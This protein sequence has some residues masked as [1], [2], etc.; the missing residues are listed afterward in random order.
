MRRGAG[1][2]GRMGEPR[3]QLVTAGRR[4]I[5]ERP[6]LTKLLDETSARVIMLVAPA[7]Y[8]KTTL[9][10][11]WLNDRPHIWHQAGQASGDFAS[12]GMGISGA[13]QAV[14]GKNAR[15]FQEWLT[16]RSGA[17][18]PKIGIGLLAADLAEWPGA[19]WLG[20]DDYQW[21]TQD[22]EELLSGVLT[23]LPDLRVLLT[24]RRRPTWVTPR[25]LLYGEVYE[26]GQ[27]VLAMSPAEASEVLAGMAADV[28]VGLVALANGWPDIIGF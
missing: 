18:E 3:E 19:T 7:G 12:V 8:G 24:S 16:T 20:I 10:R 28:S 1:T 17:E 25:K 11:Q 26:L 2:R 22:S 21:L 9:A 23:E 5:I 14:T 4:H 13:A 6:R 27:A 15:Q